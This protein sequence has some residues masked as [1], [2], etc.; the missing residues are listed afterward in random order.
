MDFKRKKLILIAG[1]FLLIAITASV[2]K[3]MPAKSMNSGEKALLQEKVSKQA[4]Q[5]AP[6]PRLKAMLTSLTK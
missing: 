6:L 5:I 4:A 1:I 2:I 3:F